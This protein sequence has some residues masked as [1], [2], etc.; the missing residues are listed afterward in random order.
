MTLRLTSFF[1]PFIVLLLLSGCAGP[2]RFGPGTLTF[3]NQRSGESSA[4][5]YRLPDGTYDAAGL[6]QI[7][8]LMRDTRLANAAPIDPALIEYLDAIC[9][10]LRLSPGAPI[11]I[12]SGYRAPQTNAEL[13]RN[14]PQVADNSYHLRGQA[15]DFKI[16]GISGRRVYEAAKDVHRGGYAYYPSSDHVHIDTGPYRTWSSY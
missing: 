16:P 9:A 12:T 5:Q 15:L 1:F 2:P 6:W 10:R 11:L 3:E 7:S 4:V 8:Y 14:S 13:R